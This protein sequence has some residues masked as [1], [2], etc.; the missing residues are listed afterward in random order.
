VATAREVMSNA[1]PAEGSRIQGL[2][3]R[4][5]GVALP[6]EVIK[7]R[8]R[9]WGERIRIDTKDLAVIIERI[10]PDQRLRGLKIELHARDARPLF[11]V[12]ADPGCR[13]T[14]ARAAIYPDSG[15]AE[16][17]LHL[18]A[19]FKPTSGVD[20]LNPPVPAG[21]DPGGVRVALVDSGINYL[22]PEIARHLAREPDG[23]IAGYDFWENDE[24]PFDQH[25][26]PS[27]FLPQHHGTRTGSL[28]AREA[29]RASLLPYR[30]PRPDMQRMQALLEHAATHRARVAAL[31]LGGN[32]REE[33]EAFAASARRHSEML[34]V[35]SAGNNG[36]DID[37]TPVYPASMDIPNMIVVTSAGDDTRPAEGSNWGAKTV[38][39]LVPA[40]NQV[41]TDFDG[42]TQRVSGSSYAVS[43]VA[44][45][46][47][48]LAADAPDADGIQ[49]RAAVL[50][51]AQRLPQLD[52]YVSTGYI[53]DPLAAP[54]DI[55]RK[56]AIQLAPRPSG[57]D[58]G[59]A[60]Q[61][62]WFRGSGWNETDIR[63]MVS[64]AAAIL[65]QC[66]ITLGPV[67]LHELVATDRLMDFDSHTSH[68]VVTL[69]G[70]QR[71]ALFLV[72]DTQRTEAFEGEAFG[73]GNTR[74]RPWLRNTVW[75]IADTRDR[76]IALAHE[77]FHVV[78]NSGTHSESDGN[79]MSTRTQTGATHLDPEQCRSAQAQGSAG[80]LL[81]PV[82]K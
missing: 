55:Q 79:L 54:G 48:R 78:S 77:L 18:D 27:L 32:R 68:T 38:D 70:L 43:R 46:A 20:L 5:H 42:S 41:A 71:P 26:V 3:D 52:R 6:V 49:L 58:Y 66:K 76:G 62:G 22:L 2:A 19:E 67:E 36:R 60:L 74:E 21:T 47:A 65:S 40:E 4:L 64:T 63:S 14:L 8:G 45:M 50:A 30:Y 82:E 1:C 29:P 72:R 80:N 69:A 25:P 10:M 75:L 12:T 51:R 31:P 17:I 53:A 81:Q 28:L 24:R 16:R 37:A 7:L 35:V 44:A 23:R 56:P 13:V 57:G 61:I 59:M 73:L 15:P 34:F 33:W 9:D 39:L 11:L